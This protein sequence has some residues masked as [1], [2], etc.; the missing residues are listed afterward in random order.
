MTVQFTT[1]KGDRR[2]QLGRIGSIDFSA[3]EQ[4]SIESGAPGEPVV[5]K[6]STSPGFPLSTIRGILSRLGIG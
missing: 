4:Y 6:H 3:H 2:R 1:E 5:L